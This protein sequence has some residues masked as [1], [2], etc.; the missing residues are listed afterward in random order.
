MAEA[1]R[2]EGIPVPVQDVVV[3]TPGL[4]G[5]VEVYRA[6]SAGYAAARSRVPL[7]SR[8]RWRRRT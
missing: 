5:Q 7:T 3:T 2:P 6:G 1:L 8:Q 4:A